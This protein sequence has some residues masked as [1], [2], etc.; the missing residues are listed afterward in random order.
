MLSVLVSVA[1][2]DPIDWLAT[3]LDRIRRQGFEKETVGVA[4]R[5]RQK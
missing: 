1:R 4:S 5:L 2:A 3:H